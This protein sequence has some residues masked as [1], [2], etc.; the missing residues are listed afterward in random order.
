M[1][2]GDKSLVVERW[3]GKLETKP[4]TEVVG[5]VNGAK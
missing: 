5:T 3:K 2:G 4:M 1:A